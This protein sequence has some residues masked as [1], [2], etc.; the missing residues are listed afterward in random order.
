[1]NKKGD[2]M[3]SAIFSTALLFSFFIITPTL[4]NYEPNPAILTGV[5]QIVDGALSI[6]Q[7]P[8][9]RPNIGYSVGNMVHGIINIIVA[10]LAKNKIKIKSQLLDEYIDEYSNAEELNEC[11]ENLLVTIDEEI[12]DEII[13]EI[14]KHYSLN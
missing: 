9:N 14:N 7:D 8:H 13:E 3:K 2:F 6:A 10:K 11:I 4:A 5:G 12:I 1:M